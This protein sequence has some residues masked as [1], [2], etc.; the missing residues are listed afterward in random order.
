LS[1]DPRRPGA[2]SKATVPRKRAPAAKQYSL[3][4]TI[5]KHSQTTNELFFNNERGEIF[6]V[7]E[8]QLEQFQLDCTSSQVDKA[9]C[10]TVI[11]Q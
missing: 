7:A 6:I 4:S 9:T 11:L 1:N 3:A 8:G 2:S 10:T 5:D